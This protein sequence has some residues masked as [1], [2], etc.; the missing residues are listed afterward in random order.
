MDMIKALFAKTYAKVI[1]IVVAVILVAGIGVGAF[2]LFS[3]D[4]SANVDNQGQGDDKD[5]NDK[6]DNDDEDE[7][8]EVEVS[9]DYEIEYYVR[10]IEDVVITLLSEEAKQL[11][12]GS[13]QPI[14][15][16]VYINDA[17]MPVNLP[18]SRVNAGD[19]VPGL[20]YVPG[21]DPANWAGHSLNNH[22]E[23]KEGLKVTI[24]GVFSNGAVS[25]KVKKITVVFDG[26][27]WRQEG[28]DNSVKYD[29]EIE[30]DVR[31]ID[32]ETV[33]LL[34]KVAEEKVPVGSY[35]PISGGVYVNGTVTDLPLSRINAGAHLPGLTYVPA[36]DPSNWAGYS[37]HLKMNIEPGKCQMVQK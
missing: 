20:T 5:K 27:Q 35:K 14:S 1:A 30:Y 28:V 32:D 3:P 34:S 7:A 37:L 2:F 4:Q 31:D 6:D 25:F 8:D 11:P 24:D 15:G 21:G 17:T 36:G 13:Y 12:A 29:F 26:K 19:H 23:V 9:Y 33:T 10:D 18:L 16:G 22:A